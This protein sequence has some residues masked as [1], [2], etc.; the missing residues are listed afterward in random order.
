MSRQR[1]SGDSVSPTLVFLS[2]IL[3]FAGG[4]LLLSALGWL[5]PFAVGL[6][7][8]ACVVLAFEMRRES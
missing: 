4:V 7:C 6:G 5:W 2:A 8:F 1:Y 3:G